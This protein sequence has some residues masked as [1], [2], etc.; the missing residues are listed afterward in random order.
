MPRATATATSKAAKDATEPKATDTTKVLPDDGP[1]KVPPEHATEIYHIRRTLARA[2]NP[3]AGAWTGP[4]ADEGIGKML[5]EGWGVKDFQI[6][7]INPEG[8]LALWIL[9]RS[10]EGAGLSEAKHIVRTLSGGGQLGTVTG[11]QADAVLSGYLSDG[12]RLEF[13]RNI[14]FDTNGINMAWMLVR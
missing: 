12:W 14:G 2:S 5:K 6:L 4:D 13:V 3:A 7:G 9:T 11:F 1:S 8:V 10:E